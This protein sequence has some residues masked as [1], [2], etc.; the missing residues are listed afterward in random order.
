MEIIRNAIMPNGHPLANLW[1]NP[2]LGQ[3]SNCHSNWLHMQ[4]PQL[5]SGLISCVAKA[6]KHRSFHS[7]QLFLGDFG[8]DLYSI[9]SPVSAAK[10][11]MS[12]G[13]LA[14][15]DSVERILEVIGCLSTHD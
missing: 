6:L 5:G 8:F 9:C 2:R 10:A 15:Y 14:G 13:S 7:L 3:T 1:K 4:S 12:D 11:I